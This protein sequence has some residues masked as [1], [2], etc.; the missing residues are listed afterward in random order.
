MEQL[1]NKYADN[2]QL[3]QKQYKQLYI[4][5]FL[6]ML[7]FAV[8]INVDLRSTRP[9]NTIENV[10]Y[11]IID[12]AFSY[13]SL[14]QKQLSQIINNNNLDLTTSPDSNQYLIEVKFPQEL[15]SDQLL[16][17]SGI[18]GVHYKVYNDDFQLISQVDKSSNILPYS[19]FFNGSYMSVSG[20]K[21]Y[22]DVFSND[23]VSYSNYE[24]SFTLSNLD[25]LMPT[26]Q[27]R[28]NSAFFMILLSLNFILI[29]I[30][31]KNVFQSKL[32]VSLGQF[33]G[34]FG[35]WVIFDFNNNAYWIGQSFRNIPHAVLLTVFALASNYLMCL[36]LKLNITILKS[37]RFTQYIVVMYKGS[38][39]LAAATTLLETIKLFYWSEALQSI[40]VFDL[41]LFDIAVSIGSLV[42]IVVTWLDKPFHKNYGLVYSIG[43]T[44]SLITFTVTQST[45]YLISH[46]G[47]IWLTFSVVYIMS[48][49]F[50]S[51][52]QKLHR[53]LRELKKINEYSTKLNE[54]LEFTQEELLMRLGSTVDLRSKETSQH[55]QRVSMISNFIA[56]ELGY[57]EKEAR[58]ISLASTL[59][60]I[61]KV[62][63][64]DRILDQPGKL[65][66]EDYNEMK[67]HAR[68][69]Y[70]ILNG[71]YSYLM[72]V[73]AIIAL[74]HHERYDG[75]GYP[76]KLAGD[77]IPMYGA[78]VAAADVFDALLSE[79]VYKKAWSYE[80]VYNFFIEQRGKHFHPEVADVVI[81]CYEELKE[82]L[83]EIQ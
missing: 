41:L 7:L 59:H 25:G 18:K 42:L 30:V 60:D 63:I 28:I 74:T 52:Q 1:E 38:L 24:S 46:W 48:R 23:M 8:F 76:D 62:G 57:N 14:D 20:S 55:V 81:E 54:E 10:S 78:I 6:S 43:L 68:M 34:L 72:D 2:T 56:I 27:F 40:Y 75:T 65:S 33:T 39:V 22:I 31:L 9:V 80:E 45:P 15:E 17:I 36:F 71:S 35:L 37:N 79:R 53:L 3:N 51:S 13:D 66:D 19:Y 82:I 61:G 77:A 5:L 64:P 83:I 49:S 58:T 50:L 21:V 4:W 47:V 73:A 69:G 70:D 16:H 26:F 67:S 29:S 12:E 11:Y 44:G 32:M